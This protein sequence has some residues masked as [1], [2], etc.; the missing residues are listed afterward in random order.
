MLHALPK[1]ARS[2]IHPAL[3]ARFDEQLEKAKDHVERLLDISDHLGCRCHNR[4]GKGMEPMLESAWSLICDASDELVRDTRLLRAAQSAAHYKIAAYQAAWVTASSLGRQSIAVLLHKT[5]QEKRAG[6]QKL[7]A[8]AL[9]AIL[10]KRPAAR[11]SGL[12]LPASTRRAMPQRRLGI[13]AYGGVLNA[14]A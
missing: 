10:P 13:G 9:K 1:M 6:A 2:A 8:L 3:I 7:R 4:G 12:I 14:V 11:R 5:L